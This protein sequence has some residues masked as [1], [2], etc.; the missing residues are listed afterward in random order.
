MV[1]MAIIVPRTA[2][3]GQW[4]FPSHST[5]VAQTIANLTHLNGN[6]LPFAATSMKSSELSLSARTMS[7]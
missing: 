4:G 1:R 3:H 7:P 5:T 6:Q 2:D